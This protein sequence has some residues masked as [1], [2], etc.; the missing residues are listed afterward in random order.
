MDMLIEKVSL[1][2]VKKNDTNE[3]SDTIEKKA[4]I[5]NTG[6]VRRALDMTKIQ[7]YLLRNGWLLINEVSSADLIVIG[8]CGVISKNERI[9]LA[10]I[11]NITSK[12]SPSSKVIITGCLPK[13]NPGKIREFGDFIFVPTRELDQFDEV[14][15]SRIKFESIPDANTLANEGGIL[16]YVLAYRFFRESFFLKLFRSLNTRKKFLRFSVFM[17]RI[18]NFIK[19]KLGLTSR[20]KIVPYYNIRISE[21]CLSTCTF[22]AIRF[23]TGKLKS[24]PENQIIEEFRKGLR[25][26]YK[27]IQ[28]VSEDTGCYGLD[29]GTTIHNLLRRILVIEEDYQLVLVDFN[30]QW[31]VKYYD[32]LLPIFLKYR[33]KFRELF[34]PLQ[35]GSN[36][37]LKA[38]RRPY[39]IETVKDKLID[40][41]K[42]VPEIMLRTTALIGF[43]GEME[44]DF[45]MTKKAVQD[46]GFSEVEIKKYEDRP[47]TASSAIKDKIPQEIVDRRYRCLKKV[48]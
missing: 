8:T 19:Y 36:R 22:C 42:Q 1:G 37:I 38:M 4:Y 28:L 41:R 20:E 3:R 40:L 44:D 39:E 27:I 33:S 10:A 24:K 35:S 29:I 32:E 17:S 18:V 26:N 11:K 48:C 47:G 13:I 21:G 12:R 6:C 30:P 16:D 43:P 15:N 2:S 25:A 7:E 34:V 23:A 9:S 14:L 5:F 31:F 45:E 46:I